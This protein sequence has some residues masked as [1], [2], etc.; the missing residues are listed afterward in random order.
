[1]RA[2]GSTVQ[3]PSLRDMVAAKD[4]ALAEKTTQQMRQSV[5]AAEAI[6]APFD[7]AIKQGHPGRAKIEATIQSLTAQSDQI[8]EAAAAVGITKLT[9]VQP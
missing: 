2:D 9:L 7:Q 1:V 8:V 3:G 4:A 6:P 5:Q